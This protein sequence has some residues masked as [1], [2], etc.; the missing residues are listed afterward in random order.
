MKLTILLAGTCVCACL[1]S[2]TTRAQVQRHDLSLGTRAPEPSAKQVKEKTTKCNAA[3][4]KKKLSGTER[5]EY[6]KTCVA[7]IPCDVPP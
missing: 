2:G 5:E 7:C 4:A 3:A 1:A 6:V